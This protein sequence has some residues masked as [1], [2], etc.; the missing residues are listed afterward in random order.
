MKWMLI[1][2][3]MGADGEY[4]TK[5]MVPFPSEETCQASVNE[6]PEH[7]EEGGFWDAVCVTKDHLEGREFM[8]D[9]PLD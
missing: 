2:F 9:V 1:V 5:V 4:Q 8:E 7:S 6:M 3:V